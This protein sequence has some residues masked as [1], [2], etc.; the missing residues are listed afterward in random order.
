MATGHPARDHARF[1]SDSAVT[2]SREY[3]TIG[4]VFTQLTG[5]VLLGAVVVL[6]TACGV[7]WH[8]RAIREASAGG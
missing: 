2:D 6:G 3:G 1:A 5:F 7:V 8:E 4:V